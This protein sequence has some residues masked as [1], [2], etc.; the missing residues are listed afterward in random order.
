MHEVS[1]NINY[2]LWQLARLA[3]ILCG[4]QSWYVVQCYANG[5]NNAND[6]APM[7]E[8]RIHPS[9]IAIPCKP[10]RDDPK[11]ISFWWIKGSG[12]LPS[13]PGAGYMR[14]SR[15]QC[16]THWATFSRGC[17]PTQRPGLVSG[18]HLRRPI[19]LSLFVQSIHTYSRPRRQIYQS[20]NRPKMCWT[21]AWKRKL[22]RNFPNE[23]TINST[24]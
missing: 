19:P 13:P 4:Y 5:Q 8:I 23:S 1:V 2:I 18:H 14:I 22:E 21:A 20:P 11:V 6:G 10:H 3:Y 15:W 9:I 17:C 16:T 12:S 7:F 24:N